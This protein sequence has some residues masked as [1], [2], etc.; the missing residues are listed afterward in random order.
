MHT[1]LLHISHRDCLSGL[2]NKLW[3]ELVDDLVS[4]VNLSLQP[5]VAQRLVLQNTRKRNIQS[6]NTKPTDPHTVF[7][8]VIADLRRLLSQF[9]VYFT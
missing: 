6:F 1:L 7:A 4:I 5:P 9:L 2:E 3:G 8:E